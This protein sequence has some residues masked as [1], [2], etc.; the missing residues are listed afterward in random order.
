VDDQPSM[1]PFLVTTVTSQPRFHVYATRP[2][3]SVIDARGTPAR[4]TNSSTGAPTHESAARPSVVLQP[5]TRET[6][7]VSAIDVGARFMVDAAS[8]R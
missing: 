2:S 1:I 6:K 7:T 4:T 8:P 3:L 5:Q